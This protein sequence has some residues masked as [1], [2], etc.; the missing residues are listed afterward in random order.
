MSS[1][2]V[3]G[4]LLQVFP[5]LSVKARNP[6]S[7]AT[8]PRVGDVKYTATRSPLAST[9]AGIHGFWAGT[10]LVNTELANHTPNNFAKTLTEPNTK[11][12]DLS[13]RIYCP[14]RKITL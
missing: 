5:P 10:T 11:K 4:Y 9:F 6:L 7:P 12:G 2:V 3:S 8:Q 14:S 1:V 13:F